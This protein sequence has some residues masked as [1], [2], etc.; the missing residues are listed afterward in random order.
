[1]TEAKSC[2]HCPFSDLWSEDA[3]LAV[4]GITASGGDQSCRKA[5]ECRSLGEPPSNCLVMKQTHLY[6]TVE[7][8]N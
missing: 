6:D 1:M 4:S 5:V 3:R 7:G 2:L 8:Y